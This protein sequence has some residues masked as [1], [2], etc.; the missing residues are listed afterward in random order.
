MNPRALLVFAISL[1]LAVA[2]FALSGA[3]F[4]PAGQ[5]LCAVAGAGLMISVLNL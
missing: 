3:G 2:G 1:A 4:D 5:M